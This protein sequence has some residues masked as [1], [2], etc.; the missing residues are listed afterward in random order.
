MGLYIA[1]TVPRSA[2]YT[3]LAS[4]AIFVFFH[5]ITVDRYTKQ[6]LLSF[7]SVC[8]ALAYL[9]AYN[10]F[11]ENRV[12]KFVAEGNASI[13][14]CV[15]T[16][17]RT[18]AVP[19]FTVS[20][21]EKNGEKFKN[22]K[23]NIY[24]D[25]EFESGDYITATGNFTKFSPK[26]NKS[27]YY[28]KGI[29]GYFK[30]DSIR[31]A[32]N[33]GGRSCLLLADLKNI[34]EES[35]QKLYTGRY[36][37]IVR[38]IGLGEKEELGGDIKQSFKVS[39]IA[40]ALVVSGLHI[41]I[42][43]RAMGLLMSF[44]P[45]SKKI[46]NVILCLFIFIFMGIIG[47]TPSV[48]RAGLL[49]ISYLLGRNLLLETDN[50]TVLA[51]VIGVTLFFNP[52]SAINASL[53]LSYSAYFG[54]VTAADIANQKG[55]GKVS[56]ALII[57]AFAAIFTSPFMAVLGMETSLLAPIFN[58][59]LSPVITVVCV[60]SFFTVII[61]KI[62]IINVI[63]RFTAVK[64]N[65]LFID[66]LLFATNFIEKHFSFA[67]IDISTDKI[68][69]LI[70]SCAVITA[71]ILLQFKKSPERKIYIFMVTL[72][73]F[74]CYNLKNANTVTVTAFDSGRETSF[75][76]QSN[77][78]KYLILSENI[79]DTK[80]SGILQ[81]QK[82]SYFDGVIYCVP[83]EADTANTANLSDRV[84][85]LEDEELNFGFFTLAGRSTKVRKD[86]L[87]NISGVTFAFG[88]GDGYS[89]TENTDFYFFG[90]EATDD[91]LADNIY[92]FYP[93]LK[94]QSESAKSSGAYELYSNLTVKINIKNG[95]Y[96]IVEDITNFG[97]G[98]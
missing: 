96:R 27:Y 41:G 72:L 87:V 20:I 89:Q 23:V 47:F 79:K 34:L 80:L 4:F 97:S 33:L 26:T 88:H 28:S 91:I 71:V 18:V 43:S 1:I 62:P 46:K 15:E 14:G 52:Y 12:E 21:K 49:M 81:N 76:L 54:V 6:L 25:E 8:T 57:S 44:L 13:V 59:L 42:I 38:A 65:K 92:F 66:L 60:L 16:V 85:I 74:V 17:S 7:V 36:L 61:G 94:N 19:C 5:K 95:K 90:S 84:Y 10:G 37:Q 45:V 77:R 93:V 2:L 9:S 48:I 67:F 40:H 11:I 58:L 78:E 83:K 56:T 75:I 35:R 98:I 51:F 69:F 86:Y 55:F 53:L 39:G 63:S 31:L 29:Y 30:A 3:T 73:C 32:D 82:I 64:I 70:F 68:R 22:F 24:I 50:Y